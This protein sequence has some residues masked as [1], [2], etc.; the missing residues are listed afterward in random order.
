MELRENNFPVEGPSEARQ[1]ASVLGSTITNE[2]NWKNLFLVI[3]ENVV[4]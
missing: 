2:Q 4:E 1:S 3:I